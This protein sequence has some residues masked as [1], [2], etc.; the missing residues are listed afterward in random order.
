LGSPVLLIQT[1]CDLPQDE[2]VR[3]PLS[4]E[5]LA[6]FPFRKIVHYSGKLDR[7]RATLDDALR[8]AVAWLTEQEGV[9]T[10]GAGRLRVKRRIEA[11][12][13]A[14]AALP[15]EQRRYR[16]ITQ[17]RFRQLCDEAGGISSAEYL[18]EYLH[19]AG[20]VFYRRGLFDDRIILDQSWALE[21]VYAV[22]HRQKCYKQLRQLG[23]RFTRPLLEALVWDGY[24]VEEQK[25]SG[26]MESCGICFC[27]A[28]G[29]T[30]TRRT[31][32]CARPAAGAR[33]GARRST[34]WQ[35]DLG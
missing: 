19:N 4:D 2:A 33:R 3:P 23:G 7:G 27:T 26:M 9:V 24:S 35:P 16:T 22:F 14:D 6:G 11:L 25:L 34:R 21:A 8:Q 32:M 29:L 30:M 12:R 15:A 5:A 1:R 31:N 17:Q 10:I 28:D 20:T 18:L 13:D